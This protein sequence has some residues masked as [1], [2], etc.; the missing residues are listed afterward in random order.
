MFAGKTKRNQKREEKKRK[1]SAKTL[2]E[3]LNIQDIK[4]NY[5]LT[6]KYRYYIRILPKNLNILTP[7]DKLDVI[8]SL[9]SAMNSINIKEFEFLITDKT[10]RLEDNKAF[11]QK[12]AKKNSSNAL[13]KELLEDELQGFNF[14]IRENNS[15][16]EFFIVIENEKE[17]DEILR[18]VHQALNQRGFDTEFCKRDELKNMLQVYLERNFSD[19]IVSDF[20]IPM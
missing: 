1:Q 18:L 12:L 6:N 8:E 10:E 20:D 3:L 19:V 14:M 16:R 13:F 7:V 5:I 11:L 2:Q 15:S 9:K 4:E 17:D